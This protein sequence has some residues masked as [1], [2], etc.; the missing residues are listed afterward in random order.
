MLDRKMIVGRYFTFKIPSDY[1]IPN[2]D[3][4]AKFKV[5]GY[6]NDHVPLRRNFYLEQS[7][8]FFKRTSATRNT[9][10]NEPGGDK[11]H[12]KFTWLPYFQYCTTVVPM[13]DSSDVLSGPFTGCWLVTFT[14]EGARY[15]AH[16]GTSELI[17]SNQ[18]VKCG[19]RTFCKTH[20]VKDIRGVKPAD[21]W[22][23]EIEGLCNKKKENTN[24]YY[25]FGLY[26]RE[27]KFFSMLTFRQKASD[28]EFRIA[29]FKEQEPNFPF[30]GKVEPFSDAELPSECPEEPQI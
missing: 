20:N 14:I 22:L 19:F 10:E 9:G 15:I 21:P 4:V 18:S 7:T 2:F 23:K 17:S 11:A 5:Y 28:S 3:N 25:M 16:I 8:G 24:G 13:D 26:T 12:R 29:G 6:A 30:N 1:Q 27:G